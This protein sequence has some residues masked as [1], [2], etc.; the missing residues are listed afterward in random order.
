M[1]Q[2]ALTGVAEIAA[3]GG[4][5]AARRDSINRLIGKLLLDGAQPSAISL[6]PEPCSGR[7]CVQ[8]VPGAVVPAYPILGGVSVQNLT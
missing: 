5:A 1:Q 6:R 3:G 7:G 8:K 2:F 4:E